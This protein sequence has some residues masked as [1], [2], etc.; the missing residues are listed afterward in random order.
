MEGLS[1]E[2]VTIIA[3]AIALAAVIVP[4]VRSLRREIGA[5]RGEIGALRGEFRNDL[6]VFREEMRGELS[7]FEEEVRGEFSSLRA[8]VSELRERMARVEGLFE[9]FT[10]SEPGLRAGS[11]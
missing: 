5:L 2:L 9:G 3:A 10:R 11:A 7:A 8:D 6:A 1:Q 4:G